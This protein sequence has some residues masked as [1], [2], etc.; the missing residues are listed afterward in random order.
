MPQSWYQFNTISHI[1]IHLHWCNNYTT[2]RGKYQVAT[3]KFFRIFFTA[4]RKI[5]VSVYSLEYF[6]EMWYY[7]SRWK[8]ILKRNDVLRGWLRNSSREEPGSLRRLSAG[9]RVVFHL[10]SIRRLCSRACWLFR[11]RNY[12]RS[13]KTICRGISDYY[14]RGGQWCD[15]GS[16]LR[17]STLSRRC[18]LSWMSRSSRV[19]LILSGAT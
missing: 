17:D 7:I 6:A 10:R 19:W 2:L 3:R 5:Y 13:T 15:S 9:S 12:S 4:R 14:E 8:T 18:C 1:K 16:T 11:L